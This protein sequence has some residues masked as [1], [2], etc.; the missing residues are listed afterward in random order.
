MVFLVRKMRM[1]PGLL[2][3]KIVVVTDRTDLEG[4]LRDTARLSGE[5]LRPNEQDQRL[6]ESPTARTQRILREPTPDICFAM[7]QKYQEGGR[8][9]DGERVSMTI[10][11]KEK[12]PGKD[13]PVVEKAVTF[14][15]S[16]D[17]ENFPLLNESAEILVLVDEAHRCNTR[18]LHR[19]LRSALPNA[20]IIGF[21]GTPILSHGQEDDGRNLR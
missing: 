1:T 11:R 6:R 2:G 10:L 14:T 9:R 19:N 21:T 15:E 8:D 18:T 5:A 7:L 4:Q 16:I 20:A 13:Q 3:F 12:K 17:F